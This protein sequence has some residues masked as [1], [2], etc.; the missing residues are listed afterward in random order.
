M[1][2]ALRLLGLIQT[3]G[4]EG[5]LTALARESELPTSTVLR[6]LGTLEIEGFVV[7]G[8][9]G[10][11]TLGP[12]LARLGLAAARAVPLHER[13]V[14]V[15]EALASGTGETASFAVRESAGR[16]VYVRQSASAAAL[17]HEGWLGRP[18]DCRRTATGNALAGRVDA[19]GGV[20]TRRTRTLGVSA[21]SAPVHDG[22]GDIVG[23]ISVTGPSVRIDDAALG[24]IR[25]AT[26]DAARR[27]TLETGGRWPHG[28]DE[29]AP[30][31]RRAARR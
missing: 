26:I 28:E 21:V 15:L 27:L 22:A 6:L 13:A 19:D 31:G 20:A 7:Q 17:R 1:G 30:S 8:A 25:R 29:P 18:F 23:A 24:R 12:T 5:S 10:H 2:R 4:T 3:A 16:A 11:W 9:D 14:P